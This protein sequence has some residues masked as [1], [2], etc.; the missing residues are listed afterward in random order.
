MYKDVK[1]FTQRYEELCNEHFAD[2]PDVL[3]PLEQYLSLATLLSEEI[4][5]LW[6]KSRDKHR[7][8]KKVYYFS[9]EF[10]IG[11]LLSQNIKALQAEKVI[12]E[13]LKHF[14]IS[15]EHLLTLESDA[16]LGNGGLGRLAA[17]FMDSMTHLGI[18]GRGNSI[19]YR[20]GFFKQ[21]IE[22][23]EQVEYADD[24]LTN[25]YPWKPSGPGAH[26]SC[27]L[28]EMLTSILKTAAWSFHTKT[29]G[30]SRRSRMKYR[31]FPI[32]RTPM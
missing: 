8:D 15:L 24:W 2:S 32:T 11:H 4:R 30:R 17:C 21:A 20:H 16:G 7:N 9:S 19:R 26:R 12:D 25:G 10:L 3:N 27:G 1:E 23:F 29:I 13:G 31:L 14:G 18:A 5:S 28:G 22:N 6:A